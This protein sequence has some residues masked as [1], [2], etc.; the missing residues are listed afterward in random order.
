MNTYEYEERAFLTEAD[1]YRVKEILENESVSYA[2][3]NK[4]S[5]FFVLPGRNLSI[6]QSNEKC[7]IKYK[8]GEIGISN[9]FVEHEIPINSESCEQVIHLFTDLLQVSPQKSEQFRINYILKNGVEVA[10]K[11]TEVWGFHLEIEKTYS[12]PSDLPKA[13]KEILET[14]KL[15]QIQLITDPEMKAFRD[16]FDSGGLPRGEYSDERFREK[17][18][19]IT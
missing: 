19:E 6:T 4:T 8:Q 9:G 14:A 2:P 17:F 5:H 7:V 12:E 15:L 18:G 10:L 13:K 1:F 11:Y 3:D 16:N